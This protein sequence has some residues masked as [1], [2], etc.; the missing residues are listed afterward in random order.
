MNPLVQDRIT[1]I[2]ILAF[3]VCS[4]QSQGESSVLTI[5]RLHYMPETLQHT[6][7]L[8]CFQSPA[9]VA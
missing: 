5:Y 4:S 3:C 7:R 9:I 6:S 8:S 2:I 1:R